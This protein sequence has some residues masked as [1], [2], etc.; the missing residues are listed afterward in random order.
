[1]K[2]RIDAIVAEIATILD[3]SLLRHDPEF[4]DLPRFHR[5][6]LIMTC[7]ARRN[8]A[9]AEKFGGRKVRCWR[10]SR[11]LENNV[12]VKGHGV[13]GKLERIEPPIVISTLADDFSELLY[14]NG[15]TINEVTD[16]VLRLFGMHAL[17]L[18][19]YRGKE[20]GFCQFDRS[21]KR[22]DYVDDAGNKTDFVDKYLV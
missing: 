4:E 21:D 12:G 6:H 19:E 7:L 5:M 13:P 16:Y 22:I 10:P 9:R 2:V 20:D 15:E 8:I 1:M 18:L 3:V 14:A 11:Q 17:G